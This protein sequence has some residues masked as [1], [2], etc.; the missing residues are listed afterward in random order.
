MPRGSQ[1]SAVPGQS[2]GKRE[3]GTTLKLNGSDEVVG[4]MKDR[5]ARIAPRRGRCRAADSFCIA[6][7]VGYSVYTLRFVPLEQ[8]GSSHALGRVIHLR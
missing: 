5:G 2:G 3:A 4:N 7:L 1:R 6:I 8:S